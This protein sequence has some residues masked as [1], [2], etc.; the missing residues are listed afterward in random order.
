MKIRTIAIISIFVF[1]SALFALRAQAQIFPQITITPD[2]LEFQD[3]RVGSTSSAMTLTA[4]AAGGSLPTYIFGTRIS[5]SSNFTIQSDGCSGTTLNAGQSCTVSLT[6]TPGAMGHYS[7]SFAMISVS[8]TIISSSLV[9]GR[10]VE[11]RVALSATNINFGDQTVGKTSSAHEILLTNS[12][13][14]SLSITSIVA[15][16][17]FAVTD[18]CG[19]SV[20]AEG[21][22]TMLVTF[23]PPSADSFTGSV[24]ITDDASDSPQTIALSG[25][26][27]APGQPDASLSRHSV[28]FGG[29]LV[30]TTSDA[31][32]V[33]LTNTGTVALTINAITPSANFAVTDDCPVPPN[34][35]AADASCNLDI[36]F[37]PDQA[38]AFSGTVTVDDDAS[39]S[40]QTI[41]LTGQGVANSGPSAS[42]STNSIDF[43]QQGINT[44]S[45][46]QTVTL[47]N[48]GDEDLTIEDVTLGGENPDAFDGT[49]DCEGNVLRP[50]ESCSGSVQFSPTEKAI[51]AAVITI[52]DNAGDS[53]QTVN[54]TGAGVRASGGNCSLASGSAAAGIVPLMALV[55][56]GLIAA[57]RRN[58]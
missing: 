13:N 2:P 53:P 46:P 51:Y 50:S 36:T 27:I 30:G 49:D 26:G 6:F 33:I 10:G 8:Q 35:L 38:G 25:R 47:T 15:S 31:E 37:S 9:E 52:I 1:V 56:I 12:G 41:S 45:Q 48:S 42:L 44:T 28:D 14:T 29:Q 43:G 55:L 20:A 40:P 11:P 32:R 23:T 21:S 16:D 57:R 22:C 5:D 54:L 4:T 39:D 34:T 58:R 19:D 7:T 3:T 24:T 17:D 18:D